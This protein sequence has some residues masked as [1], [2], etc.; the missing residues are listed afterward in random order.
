MMRARQGLAISGATRER[1]A[2]RGLR[3][4]GGGD[5]HVRHVP[6]RSTR[7]GVSSSS[8]SIEL[9]A[10]PNDS[11]RARR[12]HRSTADACGQRAHVVLACSGLVG[13][14]AD[15]TVASRP[16]YCAWLDFA[17]TARSMKTS[18]TSH[19]DDFPKVG[20]DAESTAS[21]TRRARAACARD[22]SA[23]DQRT[24]RQRRDPLR[25][26]MGPRASCACV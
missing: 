13:P 12:S 5:A 7:E 25:A 9:Q 20:A 11:P 16:I 3:P 8:D 15:M 22:S 26:R 10:I 14:R 24:S 6:A 17:E 23:R 19:Q 4:R 18:G 1:D 2:W 21:R